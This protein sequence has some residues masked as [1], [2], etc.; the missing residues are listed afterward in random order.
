MIYW[1]AALLL[2][3]LG[4]VPEPADA[5][6]VAVVEQVSVRQQIIVRVPTRPLGPPAANAVRWE[7]NRGPKCVSAKSIAGATLLGRNSVDLI[8]RDSRRVR[9]KLQKSCPAL[10][11]YRGFYISPGP[12]GMVCADRDAIRSRVGGSCEIDAYRALTAKPR[13]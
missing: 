10:D 4:G 5:P 8:L 9:A 11:Y 2:I 12:D 13:D 7:E 1:G 3:A 6:A